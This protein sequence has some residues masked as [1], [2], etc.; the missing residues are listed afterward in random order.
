MTTQPTSVP[1]RRPA[2]QPDQLTPA[3]SARIRADAARSPSVESLN[4]AERAILLRALL[5]LTV[6]KSAFDDDRVPIVTIPAEKI[7]APVQKLGG[8]QHAPP[9][10]VED[11]S[12]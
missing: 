3:R 10:G 2:D 11:M 4:N 5:E 7:D 9:L 12:T 8:D 1:F 6:T